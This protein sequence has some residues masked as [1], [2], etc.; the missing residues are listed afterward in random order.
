M[1]TNILH[2]QL[3]Y[4][5]RYYDASHSFDTEH[6]MEIRNPARPSHIVGMAAAATRDQ[7]LRAV[8]AA[9]QAFP[10]WAATSPQHRAELLMAAAGTVMEN[11]EQEARLYLKKTARSLANPPLI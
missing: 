2:T 3:Y 7:A 1:K 6:V 11:S 5:G 4:G 9:K 8:S 10:D